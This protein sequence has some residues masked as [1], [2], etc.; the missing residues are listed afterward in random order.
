MIPIYIIHIIH[1]SPGNLIRGQE[2]LDNANVR[3]Y[4]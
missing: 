2:V 3:S 1:V 4:S